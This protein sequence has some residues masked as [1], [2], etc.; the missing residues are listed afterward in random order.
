MTDLFERA[1]NFSYDDPER[2]E[3]VRKVWSVTPHMIDCYTDN[4]N[5]ERE[6]AIRRWCYDNIGEQAYPIHGREGDWQF[7]GATIFGWTFL[8]FSSKELLD[9]FLEAFP[10]ATRGRI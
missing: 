8:G 9:K 4:I 10:D 6:R 2:G 3:L 1:I 5:S 7:G